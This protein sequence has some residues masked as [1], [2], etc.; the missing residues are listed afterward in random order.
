MPREQNLQQITRYADML[1]GM[2]TK[3]GF[4]PDGLVVGE[5]GQELDIPGSTLSHHLQ[6]LKHENLVKVRRETTFLWYS[7]DTEERLAFLYAGCCTR[8]KAVEPHAVIRV[9]E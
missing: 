5:I 6:K 7:A 3:P 9:C 8:N 2:G 1:S 4:G